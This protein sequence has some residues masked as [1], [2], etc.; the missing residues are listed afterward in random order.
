[1]EIGNFR[2]DADGNVI[3]KKIPLSRSEIHIS[4]VL[5]D[6]CNRM[7]DYVRAKYKSNGKLTIMKLMTESGQ[8]NPDMSIVD[9]IQDGDLNKSLKHYV[10]IQTSL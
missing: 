10:S 1:M 3:K 5:D 7:D 8:M 2:L 4:D 6:I 9:I